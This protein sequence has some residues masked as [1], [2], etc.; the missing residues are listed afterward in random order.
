[1]ST[2]PETVRVNT[3]GLDDVQADLSE[4]SRRASDVHA[5]IADRAGQGDVTAMFGTDGGMR[6]FEDQFIKVL[7]ALLPA[8]EGL[9]RAFMAASEGVGA[10]QANY[11]GAARRTVGAAE[12]LNRAIGNGVPDTAPTTSGRTTR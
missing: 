12:D 4:L 7:H 2:G 5:R 11:E 9:V 8:M 3:S 10:L 1:M 6:T